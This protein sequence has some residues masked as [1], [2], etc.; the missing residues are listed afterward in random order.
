MELNIYDG[1]GILKFTAPASSS[2]TWSHELM[3]E[4]A[5]LSVLRL[6]NF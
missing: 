5:S 1:E 4:I 2:C 6:L 3:A